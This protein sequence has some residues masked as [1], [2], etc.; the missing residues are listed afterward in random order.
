VAATLVNDLVENSRPWQ[1]SFP[2]ARD[3]SNWKALGKAG[4]S[5]PWANIGK[6]PRK[7]PH[8]DKKNLDF[9][10]QAG[11]CGVKNF[12]WYSPRIFTIPGS[13]ILE[14]FADSEN[15]SKKC[16]PIPRNMN[17]PA[18]SVMDVRNM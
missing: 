5:T 13:L 17:I 6:T 3:H 7:S 11:G 18:M 12:P 10:P 4:C 15:Y 8:G 1:K 9:R 14:Q 2:I 16:D